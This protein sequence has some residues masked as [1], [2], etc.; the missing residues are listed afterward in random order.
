M[1]QWCGGRA[2]STSGDWYTA[3]ELTGLPGLPGTVF[4]LRKWLTRNNVPHRPRVMG[5]GTEYH[6]SGL[7]SQTVVALS[8]NVGQPPS[9][10]TSTT[11]AEGACS[12][13]NPQDT[14]ACS[15]DFLTDP[16]R[17]EARRRAAACMAVRR[18][19]DEGNS[20]VAAVAAAAQSSKVP[21]A[22]LRNWWRRVK[23]V[24]AA[25][26]AATLASRRGMSARARAAFSEDAWQF[27]L[28]DYLRPEQPCLNTCY[29]RLQRIAQHNGWNVPSY[30]TVARRI[31]ALPWQMVVLARQ[32]EDGLLRKLPVMTRTRGH[33]CAMQA[34]NADGH[35]FDVL[36]KL[37][38]G[39]VGRPMLTA[40]QDLYSGK[41]LSWR[42]SET[43]NQH[44]VRL[45]FGDMVET[46]GVPQH[47]YLDNGREFA[48]KWLTGK[49]A[50]RF[51]FTVRDEDPVGIF[52]QL[53]VQVHWTTPYHG[54][55]KPIERAFKDLC[56][57]IAKHPVNAGAYTG[58]SP[59]TKPANYGSRAVKWD[60]FCALVDA[61]IAAHN[62]RVGRRTETARGRSF[63]ETFAESYARSTVT[64]ATAE[65][66]RLWLLA[67]EGVTVRNT[68]HV[69]ILGNAYWGEE[70]APIAGQ[71]VVVRFDPEHLER[72]VSVYDADG[73]LLCEA[74]RTAAAFDDAEAAKE[75]QRANRQ[76][77]KAAKAQLSAERRMSALEAATLL[78]P[79][80]GGGAERRGVYAEDLPEPAAVRI[81]TPRR[82]AVNEGECV[83]EVSELVRSQERLT[84]EMMS[85]W[86][87]KRFA[88]G[89]L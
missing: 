53:G 2:T 42:L 27:L 54:Q 22:T 85:D 56:E 35:K 26:W 68:G 70:L 39:V 87:E 14:P 73:A 76:R 81:L 79:M 5:K 75:H 45:S 52:A 24:P 64:R 58:N 84:L 28:R 78:S 38:S 20:L 33:L 16:A 15:L 29:W 3:S 80:E 4:G 74:Y 12:T 7:P 11:T 40:W 69:A 19:M 46:Y 41:I 30:S 25:D 72:N 13:S 89:G 63:D 88:L 67:A 21:A 18:L 57:V 77:I 23:S 47:A 82:R 48:N 60:D 50:F 66:R 32:G 9:A 86:A 43:L 17:A 1:K 61:E 55:S 37:P 59:V 31:D 44:H 65:Q 8:G 49:A 34:V 6:I 62:A 71:R 83:D 51:R 36:C 10:V